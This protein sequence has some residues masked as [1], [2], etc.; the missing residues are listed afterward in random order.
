METDHVDS[1]SDDNEKI[2]RHSDSH[3][4]DWTVSWE[5]VGTLGDTGKGSKQ[6]VDE[7]SALEGKGRMGRKG[8]KRKVCDQLV[9]EAG[10][11]LELRGETERKY[12]HPPEHICIG[13]RWKG[14]TGQITLSPLV[15]ISTR[16]THLSPP[17]HSTHQSQSHPIPDPHVSSPS[18]H[19]RSSATSD[20]VLLD[21]WRRWFERFRGVLEEP[22]DDTRGSGRANGWN[23]TA[24][25]KQAK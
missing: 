11:D 20:L 2:L 7:K 25:S 13:P 16:R 8:K 5:L 22:F 3:G 19:S 14:N 6:K 12:S 18:L 21:I 23:A 17:P 4:V 9:R 24:K 10:R 1:E 15:S